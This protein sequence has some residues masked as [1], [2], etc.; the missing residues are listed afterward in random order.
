MELVGLLA[1]SPDKVGKDAGE[2]VGGE[3]VG[4]CA[5]DDFD[6]VLSLDADAVS[7]NALGDTPQYREQLSIEYAVCWNR[8]RTSARPR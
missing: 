5:T 4:V 2:I 8:E 6:K 3:S 1:F 7:F